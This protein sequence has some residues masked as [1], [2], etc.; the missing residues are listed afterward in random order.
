MTACYN[1]AEI[2]ARSSSSVGVTADILSGSSAKR[3]SVSRWRHGTRAMRC[4]PTQHANGPGFV[5]N[6]VRSPNAVVRLDG[7]FDFH[8]KSLSRQTSGQQFQNCVMPFGPCVGRSGTLLDDM[9][10]RE[11]RLRE[12]R[13][14][15]YKHRAMKDLPD[16]T[17]VPQF[18]HRLTEWDLA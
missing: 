4:V 16:M 7:W 12:A 9:R 2:N 1:S 10:D 13:T 17:L 8:S 3:P 5:R 6:D 11:V 14:F 15:V 18:T